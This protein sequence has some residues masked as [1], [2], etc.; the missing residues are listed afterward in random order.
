MPR[1]WPSWWSWDLE[2]S[3]HLLKRMIDRDFTEVDLREMLH[4][5]NGHRRDV[6]E[7]RW[8]IETKHRGQEW[9]VIVEP[10]AELSLLVIVTAY[11]VN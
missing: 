4:L 11:P 2:L 6:V 3:P 8:V 10:D 7:Y 9:E 1:E 5:A